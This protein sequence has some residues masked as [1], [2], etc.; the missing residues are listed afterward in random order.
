M[1]E[2]G[3]VVKFIKSKS[4]F[5]VCRGKSPFTLHCIYV[6]PVRTVVNGQLRQRCSVM[7]KEM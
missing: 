1:G 5:S 3:G 6:S 2:G 7:V 4:L